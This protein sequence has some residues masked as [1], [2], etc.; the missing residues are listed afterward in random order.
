MQEDPATARDDAPDET[1]QDSVP[2]FIFELTRA[3]NEVDCV[4][5]RERSALLRRAASTIREY[6]E[7]M[8]GDVERAQL[9]SVEMLMAAA[10]TPFAG[11]D[12]DVATSLRLAAGLI[13]GYRETAHRA[14]H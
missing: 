12:E 5:G 6:Q 2:A 9:S 10:E 3:A 4:S 11:S 14:R 8:L 7:A 13:R 1:A